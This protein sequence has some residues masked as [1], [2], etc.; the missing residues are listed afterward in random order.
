MK[1]IH[2]YKIGI[3]SVNVLA[4]PEGAQIL[5]VQVQGSQCCVWALVDTEE[6]KFEK[7]LILCYGTGHLIES[8][9]G[10]YIN[11]IQL[12]GGALVLHFFEPKIP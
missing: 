12:D 11:T 8:E 4:L 7:R 1:R 10:R 2:K 5:T 9:T 6:E 3:T